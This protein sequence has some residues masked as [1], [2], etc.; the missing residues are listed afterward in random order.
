MAFA[1]ITGTVDYAKRG[2]KG[3]T[4]IESWQAQ[5][6]DIK[7]RWSIWFEEETPLEIGQQV[8]LTGVLSTKVGEPW[9]DREGQTRPGGVEHTL[10]KTKFR[11]SKGQPKQTV[12][13]QAEQPWEPDGFAAA[14]DTAPAF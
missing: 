12:Q 9:E 14:Y 6:M 2:G 13:R 11:E 3:Y 10:N 5:G 8:S 4:I 7:R 1:S